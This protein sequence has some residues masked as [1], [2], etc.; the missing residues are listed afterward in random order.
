MSKFISVKV[1]RGTFPEDE[2]N[3]QFAGQPG[4]CFRVATDDEANVKCFHVSE[5]PFDVKHLDDANHVKHFVFA[6]VVL[7]PCPDA[8]VELL[9]AELVA[10]YKMTEGEEGGIKIERIK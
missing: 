9:G 3:G 1:F 6:S 4:A 2:K 7:N 10:E 5:P 8:E